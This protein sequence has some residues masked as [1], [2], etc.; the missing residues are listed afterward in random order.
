VEQGLATVSPELGVV[1]IA[2]WN[3]SSQIVISGDKA[4]VEAGV[5]AVGAAKAVFLPVSAPFHCRL[6]L[7][8]EEKLALDL[9]CALFQDLRFPIVNNV[10]VAEIVSAAQARDGVKRQVSRAVLWQGIMEKLL[11]E[12]GVRKFAEVGCGKVLSGLI[13]RAAKDLGFSVDIL[14][15]ESR[16]DLEKFGVL[17]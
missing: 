6:M 1:E 17:G 5:K 2:N 16:A 12:K 4:A 13:K 10:D 3:S 7:P 15:F 9:D 11:V 8:A 14:N